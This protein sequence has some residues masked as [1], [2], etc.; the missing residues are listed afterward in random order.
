MSNRHKSAC[1][2]RWQRGTR[3]SGIGRAGRAGL[4]LCG[5]LFGLLS[6]SGC[7]L[8]D[9]ASFSYTNATSEH[10][11]AGSERVT[12]VPFELVNNHIIVPVSINGSEPLN[13]VLDSAAAATVVVDSRRSRELQLPSAGEV[14]VSGTGSGPQPT[15]NIVKG[16]EVSIGSVSLLAQSL[17]SLP[18][19]ALPFFEELDEVYFD[20][21]VGYDFLRRFVVE[22]NYDQMRVVLAETDNY[23]SPFHGRATTW[24]TLPLYVDGAM[25]YLSAVVHQHPAEAQAVKLL[26]DTGSTSSFSLVASSI[27]GLDLPQTYFVETSQGLAGDIAQRVTQ[28]DFLALGE[29]RLGAIPGRYS[30]AGEKGDSGSNGILGNRVLSRFN[31][32]FD[33]ANG[34]LALQPNDRF[35]LPLRADRSG[36][37]IQPHARGAVV[38]NVAV[39]TAGAAAGLRVGD[40]IT[41]VDERPVTRQS[42]DE[43]HR[44]LSSTVATVDLCWES[45]GQQRCGQ[46]ELASRYQ[47]FAG[48]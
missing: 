45:E 38:K 27:G 20:G 32:I 42:V 39:G 10:A 21:I 5:V 13:F 36:L 18:L 26:V 31:L 4:C 12:S 28:F 6:L 9:M 48:A 2:G 25:P 1:Q 40:I 23:Q 14:R 22:V 17:I 3:G 37:R 24:Q 46:L 15:A 29:Y 33:Y 16:A 41:L 11:W 35:E 44:A 47:T 7:Q 43:L 34:T 30:V 8:L 19:E